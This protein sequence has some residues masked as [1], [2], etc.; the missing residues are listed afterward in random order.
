MKLFKGERHS[1]W[2]D[3]LSAYIDGQLGPNRNEALERHLAGCVACREELEELRSVV[4]LLH[5]VPDVPVPHS[6]TLSQAPT[7]RVGWVTSY[8]L[9]LRYATGVVAILFLAVLVGDLVTSQPSV[10]A[11]EAAPAVERQT[12][13]ASE[14]TSLST[15]AA[16]PEATAAVEN[17]PASAPAPAAF[18]EEAA[19]PAQPVEPVDGETRFRLAEIA[20]GAL[21]AVLAALAAVQWYMARR[22][23]IG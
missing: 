1:R 22:T 9:P 13:Q 18:T 14:D 8:A 4:A 19:E 11:P 3:D 16:V 20:L 7:K 17:V 2:Q 21:A 12:D 5:M 15:D 10:T 6:F 23:R